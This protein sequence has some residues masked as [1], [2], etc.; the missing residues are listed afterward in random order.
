MGERI[1]EYLAYRNIFYDESPE[2]AAQ[3]KPACDFI[4]KRFNY[5]PCQYEAQYALL[6]EVTRGGESKYLEAVLAYEHGRR[7]K[8][9]VLL[10]SN[11]FNACPPC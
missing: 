7:M 6:S 3:I 9:N 5:F 4:T 1:K 2:A 10:N 11:Y 8:G